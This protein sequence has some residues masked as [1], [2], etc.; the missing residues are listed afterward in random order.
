[1]NESIN[2]KVEFTGNKIY[3][4]VCLQEHLLLPHP[5]HTCTELG[6]NYLQ[7]IGLGFENVEKHILIL[8]ILTYENEHR[9]LIR[10]TESLSYVLDGGGSD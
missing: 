1:M 10:N 9:I 5:Q 7:I 8:G 2:S 4:H 3:M 6:K